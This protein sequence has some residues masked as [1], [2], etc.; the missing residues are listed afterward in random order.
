VTLINVDHA[1]NMQADFYHHPAT[2]PLTD[3]GN[4]QATSS[5]ARQGANEK[6][7]NTI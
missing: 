5:K 1:E 6:N 7:V 4:I 2:A 3:Q